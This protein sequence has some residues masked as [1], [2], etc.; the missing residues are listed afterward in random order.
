MESDRGESTW[1]WGG[2]DTRQ[3]RHH[4]GPCPVPPSQTAGGAE[5]GRGH[6]PELTTRT[7]ESDSHLFP[8]RP[9]APTTLG[10]GHLPPSPSAHHAQGWAP[11][12]LPPSPSTH[13]A[14]GWAP[15]PSPSTHYAQ[16]RAAS[17]LD[18][19]HPDL[20]PDQD[21]AVQQGGHAR[22]L[23]FHD[24]G[25]QVGD[26]H[27]PVRPEQEAGLCPGP[28]ALGQEAGEH[29]HGGALELQGAAPAPPGVL[30][31]VLVLAGA[32]RPAGRRGRSGQGRGS[33]RPWG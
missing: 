2:Q 22:R 14:Q 7:R 13:H 33:Q 4:T 15:A 16:G 30:V 9:A 24:V 21:P 23:Q 3:I 11:A 10:A 19:G 8:S 29:A 32:L 1:G 25:H 12:P 17:Y 31:L 20:P 27:L 26:V 6:E 5:T 28:G 18:G